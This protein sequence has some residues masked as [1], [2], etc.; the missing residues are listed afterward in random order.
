MYCVIYLFVVY[1]ILIV[2]TDFFVV[3]NIVICTDFK[4]VVKID[5][6][7]VYH[8]GAVLTNLFADDMV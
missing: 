4:C 6:F 5:L 2:Q 1:H 3:N 7:L 8:S